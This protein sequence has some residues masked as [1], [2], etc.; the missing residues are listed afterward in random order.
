MWVARQG[1]K[2]YLVLDLS[3][4]DFGGF[5]KYIAE[6][7]AFIAKQ[8]G[9]Y[10]VQGARPTTIE[11]DWKSERIVII[12]FPERKNA[13]AFLCDAEIQDLFKIR[14]DTTT[15]KLLLVDGARNRC[16]D[17]AGRSSALPKPASKDPKRPF[18]ELVWSPT[19]MITGRHVLDY[20][21]NPRPAPVRRGRPP[22]YA[23][24][25]GPVNLRPARGCPPRRSWP[26]GS[27]SRAWWCG[28]RCRG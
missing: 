19:C 23:R 26:S 5:R 18:W 20:L 16:P 14:H 13:E 21:S 12:E 11:G 24:R 10:I 1:M 9:K 28:R 17:D 3:V 15:G 8:S 4:N 7:P 25:S 27:R 2:A 6:I 22:A